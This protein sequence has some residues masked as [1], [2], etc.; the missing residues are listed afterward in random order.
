[1]VKKESVVPKIGFEILFEYFNGLIRLITKRITKPSFSNAKVRSFFSQRSKV[2]NFDDFTEST[3]K[4]YLNGVDYIITKNNLLNSDS[5]SEILDLGSGRG[6]ILNLVNCREGNFNYLG[7][8]FD[9]I[10]V[11][12]CN[13]NY[14][15]KPNIQFQ[16]NDVLD[17]IESCQNSYDLVF[18]VNLLPY[19]EDIDN[20]FHKLKKNNYKNI[21]ICDP[22]PSLYWEDSFGGFSIFIRKPNE[23][24]KA[25]ITKSFKTFDEHQLYAFKIFNRYIIRINTTYFLN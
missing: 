24:K 12:K 19:I 16:A 17:F 18:I 7:V 14:Q 8:D 5:T 20:I 25:L 22:H 1:M 9:D 23:M 10:A 13:Q 6:G 2:D 3:K 21:I 4:W 11:S 15:D